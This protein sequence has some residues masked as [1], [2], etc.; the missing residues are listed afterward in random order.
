[1]SEP[2]E[3]YHGGRMPHLVHDTQLK[4]NWGQFNITTIATV[5]GLGVIMWG[6]SSGYT[7]LQERQD[8]R[9]DAIESRIVGFE[10]AMQRDKANDD[11]RYKAGMAAVRD[12]QD[13]LPTVI[14]RVT[15]LEQNV[16]ATNAR[17]DTG[18]AAVNARIDR[19][20]D[21][22]QQLQ[23]KAADIRTAIEVLSAEVKE[24]F[25]SSPGPAPSSRTPR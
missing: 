4:V 10:G 18:I 21:S 7:R 24:K 1:M 6:W 23:E 15:T 25:V 9:I 14:H 20:G 19:V 3:Q 2:V 12:V 5:V 13:T 22:L 8:A 16:A 17:I 11:D